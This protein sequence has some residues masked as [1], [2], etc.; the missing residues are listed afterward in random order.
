MVGSN[1]LQSELV[2][3]RSHSVVVDS[4]KLQ[5]Q[6]V[7]LRSA[8]VVMGSNKL[9]S[10]S[11]A[12]RSPSMALGSNAVQLALPRQAQKRLQTKDRAPRR[13]RTATR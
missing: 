12:L 7:A 3:L 11:V 4:N 2:A 8:S 5:P 9:Q 6:S 13:R 10:Q 1:A